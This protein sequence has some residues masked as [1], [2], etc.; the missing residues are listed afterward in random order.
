MTDACFDEIKGGSKAREK[1]CSQ[2]GVSPQLLFES[3]G[4]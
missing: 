1:E 2:S 4:C 3:K